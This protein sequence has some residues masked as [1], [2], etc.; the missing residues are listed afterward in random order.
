MKENKDLS[1]QLD[2]MV[3]QCQRMNAGKLRM[4]LKNVTKGHTAQRVWQNLMM[5]LVLSH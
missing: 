2:A 5:N 1:N 3:S 4:S